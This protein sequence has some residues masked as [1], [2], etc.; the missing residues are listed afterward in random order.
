MKA[1]VYKGPRD[2]AI[3]DVPDAKIEKPTDVV[4]EITTTNICG[5]DLH[6]YEGRTDVEKGKVLGHENLGKVV[7]VGEA[8]ASIKK[9]DYV[10]LPFN[11]ACGFCENCERGLTGFC[12]TTN[13]PSAG[14]AYGFADMGPYN[15]GQAELLRVPFA[16]FNC[17]KLPDDAEEKQN[18]YVMLADIFPTGWHATRL[19][20]IKPGDS[21]SIYGAGPVGLMSTLSSVLQGASKI[22]VVDQHPDRLK[23]A[24]ELGAIPIDQSKGDPAKQILD[25]TEGKGTDCGVEAVGYQCHDHHGH[26]VPNMTM[27]NLVN[28]VKPTGGIGV[29]GV[30]VPKD[31]KSDDKLA[32]EGKIAFDLG[33]FWFKGQKMGT[34]QANVKAYNRK[35]RDLI[36]VGKAAPSK[37]I[38]HELALDEAPDA[39]KNFDNRKNGWTKV[40]LK[41]KSAAHPRKKSATA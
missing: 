6:M 22:F 31:P 35:L 19:A 16:D 36:H 41:P 40:V 39:Y 3:K 7:E 4:V 21:I 10:C 12:L 20:G 23:L 28:S 2:V 13:P 8:V 29:I 33:T 5:S 27:N 15:G 25:Q 11:I 14:A 34:G 26:E 30:F 37:I 1:L 17:L 9:G 38:S 24:K 18:D 32:K